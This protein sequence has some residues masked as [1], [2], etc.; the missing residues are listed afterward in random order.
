MRLSLLGWGNFSGGPVSGEFGLC[1]LPSGPHTRKGSKQARLHAHPYH[2]PRLSPPPSI[3]PGRKGKCEE[4]PRGLS[5][6]PAS[7][8]TSHSLEYLPIYSSIMPKL[9]GLSF[10]KGIL[11]AAT[12]LILPGDR[13]WRSKTAR[14]G[15]LYPCAGKTVCPLD[16]S[17]AFSF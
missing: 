7:P 13:G 2:R 9:I 11:L 4:D 8:I 14:W 3:M 12:C 16:I 6:P 17:L 10:L 1:L 15:H 5:W